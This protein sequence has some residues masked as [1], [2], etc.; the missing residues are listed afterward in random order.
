MAEVRRAM[1]AAAASWGGDLG[2][3]LLFVARQRPPLRVPPEGA[4][5]F[6]LNPHQEVWAFRPSTA[7]YRQ[8]TAED[9]HVLAMARAPDGARIA[10]VTGEKLVRGATGEPALRGVA[11][12]ELALATM[13]AGTPAR[14][15]GDV[16]RLQIFALPGGFLLHVD[17]EKGGDDLRLTAAGSLAPFALRGRAGPPLAVLTG[18]GATLL[19]EQR[20][21]NKQCRLVA[22][23]ERGEGGVPV[24]VVAAPGGK[25]VP[26][27]GGAGAG[28]S[29]LPIP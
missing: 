24:I 5:V 14:I 25:P 15:A 6:I 26:I 27:K 22:R 18:R 10:V 23:E 16:R 8:I 19:E 29:G 4:G 20:F 11:V 21:G 7:R 17:G 13:T 9:G 3:S 28:L 2:D 12:R 1:A